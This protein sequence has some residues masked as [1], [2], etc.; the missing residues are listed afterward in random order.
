VV[1]PAAPRY[2]CAQWLE[3]DFR[4]AAG[5]DVV[6]AQLLSIFVGTGSE[7]NDDVRAWPKA[8]IAR[9]HRHNAGVRAIHQCPHSKGNRRADNVS[10]TIKLLFFATHHLAVARSFTLP[11]ISRAA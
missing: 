6:A 7:R 2:G 9:L 4:A 1:S 10:G 8:Y 11:S 5:N 3:R